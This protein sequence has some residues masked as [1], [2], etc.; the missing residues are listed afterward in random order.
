M[1]DDHLMTAMLDYWSGNETTWCG[2]RLITFKVVIFNVSDFHNWPFSLLTFSEFENPQHVKRKVSFCLVLS[3][4]RSRETWKWEII[5]T[6]F[7]RCCRGQ[8]ASEPSIFNVSVPF[9]STADI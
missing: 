1:N 4:L 5:V 7:L 2:R 3:R 8:D 9:L 6:R